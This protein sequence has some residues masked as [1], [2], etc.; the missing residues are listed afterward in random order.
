MNEGHCSLLVVAM[1]CYMQI[2]VTSLFM[3]VKAEQVVVVAGDESG[4]FSRVRFYPP[5]MRG[6]N[7]DV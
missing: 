1:A 6:K 3:T 4:D 2:A 5:A 7:C